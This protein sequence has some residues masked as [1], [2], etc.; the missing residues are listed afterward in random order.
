MLVSEVRRA[1]CHGPAGFFFAIQS[2]SKPSHCYL[3]VR[4]M[5]RLVKY[6]A[7]LRR[8]RLFSRHRV[9]LVP[10]RLRQGRGCAVDARYCG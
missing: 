1:S 6:S 9:F 5:V 8:P 10:G 4:Q 3:Q 2:R 7:K